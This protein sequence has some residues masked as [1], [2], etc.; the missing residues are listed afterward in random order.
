MSTSKRFKIAAA[1]MLLVLVP[2]VLLAVKL[3]KGHM[4]EKDSNRILDKTVT[5]RMD[6]DLSQLTDAERNLI[7]ERYEYLKAWARLDEQVGGRF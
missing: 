1:V 7:Q 6:P 2:A 5:I 3:P 4:S